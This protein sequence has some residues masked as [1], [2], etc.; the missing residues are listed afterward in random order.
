M[1]KLLELK[2]IVICLKL[3]AMLRFYGYLS[4]LSTFAH[5]VAQ[6]WFALHETWHTTI[7][8]IYYWVEVVRIENNSPMIEIT[9]FV[10]ILRVLKLFWHFRA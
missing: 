6:T 5:K 3:R 8:V 1:L 9:C 10:A 7:F 4:F 2:I